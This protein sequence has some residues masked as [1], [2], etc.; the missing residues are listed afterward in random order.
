[1]TVFTDLDVILLIHPKR[2]NLIM[3]I[4]IFVHLGAKS[5]GWRHSSFGG[6]L[7]LAYSADLIRAG[8]VA[9]RG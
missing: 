5:C 1:V 7:H 2:V 3:E 8:L 6:V 9:P 4:V